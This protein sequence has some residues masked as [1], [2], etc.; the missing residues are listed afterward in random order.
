MS[1]QLLVIVLNKIEV[2]N[3]LLDDLYNNGI[4]GAT[5]LNSHGMA[6]TLAHLDEPS[7]ISSFRAFFANKTDENKTILMVLEQEQIQSVKNI[8]VNLVGDLS[9]P[10]TAFL[11]A[12]PVVYVEGITVI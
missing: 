8:V 10:N 9:Q 12:V 3:E 2:M 6:Q 4:K 5:I 11:F 7:A 1:K